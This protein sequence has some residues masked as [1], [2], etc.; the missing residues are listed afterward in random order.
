MYC[1]QCK[2]PY[3]LQQKSSAFYKLAVYYNKRIDRIVP[4]VAG[5]GAIGGAYIALTVQGWYSIVTFCGDELSE[6]LF[7]DETWDRPSTVIRFLF[8]MQFVPLWLLASRTRY[9]DSVLPFIPLA[10]VE[11]DNLVLYPQPKVNLFP[12]P[13]REVLPPGLT[14]CVLPWLRI[15]YNKLWDT[16]IRPMERKWDEAEASQNVRDDDQIVVRIAN[17]E[18]EEQQIAAGNNGDGAAAVVQNQQQRQQ[19]Q[20]QQPNDFEDVLLATN[21]STLCRKIVGALLLP[22]ACS[23]AGFL[24][25]NIPWVRR[26]FPDRFSRNVIGGLAFLV[27]KVYNVLPPVLICRTPSLFGT[28]IRH[29]RAGRV[30]V[31]WIMMLVL[32]IGGEQSTE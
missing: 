1:P 23:L 12:T 26:K 3:R 4:F 15:V 20:Q 32:A 25:G 31:S 6:R 27:L 18:Q 7:S 8:G 11:Q 10:F 2:E 21:L 17:D 5:L 22:D 30:S 13:R 28:S 24:I 29:T 9:L 19:Q 14:M 16:I